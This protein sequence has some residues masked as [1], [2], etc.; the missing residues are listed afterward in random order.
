MRVRALVPSTQRNGGHRFCLLHAQSTRAQRGVWHSTRDG[1]H[2]NSHHL[3][4]GHRELLLGQ[5]IQDR[6]ALHVLV[7]WLG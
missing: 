7:L 1:L 4:L 2:H 6:P 3:V 5:K